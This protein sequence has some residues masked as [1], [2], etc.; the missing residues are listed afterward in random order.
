[1]AE[2]ALSQTLWLISNQFLQ[3]GL[4]AWTFIS[5][6]KVTLVDCNNCCLGCPWAP[7]HRNL[8]VPGEIAMGSPE[9]T[10]PNIL[11]VQG[12]HGT[13]KRQNSA[14]VFLRWLGKGSGRLWAAAGEHPPA[15]LAQ[16]EEGA[17]VLG[18]FPIILSIKGLSVC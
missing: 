10:G 9:T 4:P 16:W 8:P 1:M 11:C 7:G 6:Q 17:V 14:L 13:E 18:A 5:S 12:V 3:A 2:L 15:H